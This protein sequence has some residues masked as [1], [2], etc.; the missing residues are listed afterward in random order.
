MESFRESG[1]YY[2]V[3][4][5]NI[6]LECKGGMDTPSYDPMRYMKKQRKMAAESSNKLKQEKYDQ[7]RY[8]GE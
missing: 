4:A 6:S 7:S 8:A 5:D 2:D 3:P 1:S